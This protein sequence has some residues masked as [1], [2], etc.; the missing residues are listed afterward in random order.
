MN[1]GIT[2]PLIKLGTRYVSLRQIYATQKQLRAGEWLIGDPGYLLYAAACSL[3]QGTDDLTEAR[4][5]H[6][7]PILRSAS[8]LKIVPGSSFE[9]R[10]APYPPCTVLSGPTTELRRAHAHRA[11]E[12][13]S[14]VKSCILW[15]PD[16]SITVLQER[17]SDHHG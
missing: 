8:C 10:I 9:L 16:S 1:S 2:E 17:E 7:D 14:L 4:I 12:G 3:I 5:E 15:T 13:W 11:R 6:L